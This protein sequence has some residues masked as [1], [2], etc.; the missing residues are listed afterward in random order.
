M[1]PSTRR[2]SGR[3]HD[4][5]FLM[6]LSSVLLLF[7]DRFYG[8]ISPNFRSSRVSVHVIN[9]GVCEEGPRCKHQLEEMKSQVKKVEHR[10]AE[11]VGCLCSTCPQQAGQTRV[12]EGP[13]GG[14]CGEGKNQHGNHLNQSAQFPPCFSQTGATGAAAAH[15][16]HLR[17]DWFLLLVHA[18]DWLGVLVQ[19]VEV[20][21]DEKGEFRTS[22]QR[23][24]ST[25]TGVCGRCELSGGR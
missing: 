8:N 20:S 4:Q 2:S 12:P 9:V 16:P 21:A 19:V 10:C 25:K 5:H 6:L 11:G 14:R 23:L 18:A 13:D 3:S 22:N 17:A 7:S 24:S 15:R 1:L